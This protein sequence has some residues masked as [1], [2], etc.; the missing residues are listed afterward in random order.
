MSDVFLIGLNVRKRIKY[1]KKLTLT[2][3][4]LKRSIDSYIYFFF[5]ELAIELYFVQYYFE[6]YH[7]HNTASF[8]TWLF[9]ASLIFL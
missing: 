2:G 8:K 6:N 4:L 5:D 7:V 3:K 1:P 9:H